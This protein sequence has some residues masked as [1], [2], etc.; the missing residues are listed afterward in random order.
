MCGFAAAEGPLPPLSVYPDA[1][2][3]TGLL[4]L[5]TRLDSSTLKK[6]ILRLFPNGPKSTGS[7]FLLRGNMVHRAI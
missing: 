5:V 2:G 6:N 4:F 7:V 1:L 3:Q